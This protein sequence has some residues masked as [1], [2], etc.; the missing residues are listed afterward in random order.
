MLFLPHYQNY[1][2][3]VFLHLQHFFITKTII[4][5]I[6]HFIIIMNFLTDQL[7]QRLKLKFYLN[8]YKYY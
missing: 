6:I 2:I 5:K 4:N 3:L 8:K 1:S 7:T